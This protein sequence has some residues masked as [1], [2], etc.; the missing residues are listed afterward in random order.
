MVIKNISNSCQK[1]I[2]YWEQQGIPIISGDEKKVNDFE[3]INGF[4]L[5]SDFKFFYALVNGMDR[6]FPNKTDKNGFL[7]YP[8]EAVLPAVL[9][10]VFFNMENMTNVFLFGDYL[11]ASWWYG[12]KVID[13][14]NYIIGILATDFFK[15]I[16]NSLIEFLDFYMN[17][18][19]ILYDYK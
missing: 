17:D 1:L 4:A 6:F 15:P 8:I 2:L 19:D 3:K 7:F 5:P 18:S 10:P 9:E 14:D 16:T 12:F 11:Q 13:N